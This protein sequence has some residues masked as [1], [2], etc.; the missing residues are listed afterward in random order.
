MH[1]DKRPPLTSHPSSLCKRVLEILEDYA[2]VSYCS[3]TVSSGCGSLPGAKC[4]PR[5]L[6][7]Y[8]APP[9]DVVGPLVRTALIL[10][11]SS[12]PHRARSCLYLPDFL[13]LLAPAS[14]WWLG[15]HS[16][17]ASSPRLSPK[18]SRPRIFASVTRSLLTPFSSSYSHC[19]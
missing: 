10:G 6:E 3:Q 12:A 2:R 4:L 5:C 7:L 19:L 17:S 13:V 11:T 15:A 16:N 8:L 9:T 1:S 18:S 14:Y